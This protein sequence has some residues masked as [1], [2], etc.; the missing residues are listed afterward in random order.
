MNLQ[1][2][3]KYD[4]M[5]ERERREWDEKL[6]GSVGWGVLICVVLLIIRLLIPE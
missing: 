5:K 2:Q 1:E 4:R 6:L 3:L